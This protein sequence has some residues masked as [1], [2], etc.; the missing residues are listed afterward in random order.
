MTDWGGRA[1][2][3][4]GEGGGSNNKLVVVCYSPPL[5]YDGGAAGVYLGQGR[6][7]EELKRIVICNK[8]GQAT[9]TCF[10]K[11]RGYM[12]KLIRH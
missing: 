4:V 11:L 6:V 8:S 3:R 10:L 5:P 9:P 7:E 1:N 12:A 2:S